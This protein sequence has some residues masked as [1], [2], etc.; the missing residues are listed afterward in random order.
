M[1]SENFLLSITDFYYPIWQALT[2]YG[3][4]N[5]NLVKIK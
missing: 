2:T 5:L 1:N 4:S 3:Y